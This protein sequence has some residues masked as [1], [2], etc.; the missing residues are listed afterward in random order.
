MDTAPVVKFFIQPHI[1][2]VV[3]IR[4]AEFT[5]Y[6]VVTCEK[7]QEAHLICHLLNEVIKRK[8]FPGPIATDAE[9]GGQE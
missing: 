3:W 4:I 6:V 2:K 9:R 8:I 7:E 1:P 5:S